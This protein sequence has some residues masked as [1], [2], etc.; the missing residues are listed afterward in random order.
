MTSARAQRDGGI[1]MTGEPETPATT[2]QTRRNKPWPKFAWLG[3]AALLVGGLVLVFNSS[4]PEA[5]VT[6]APDVPRVEG[7]RIAFSDTFA[8]RIGLETAEVRLGPL[9]PVISVVGTVALDPEHLAAVGTRLRGLVRSMHKFEGDDVKKGELLAEID[10]AELGEAQASVR[11]LGAQR[12]AAKM[13]AEREQQ[14]LERQLSTARE[15]EVAMA[16]LKKYDALQK[17][18]QQRVR[19][20]SGQS[21][22]GNPALGRYS[23]RSPIDGTIIDRG[24]STGQSVEA[25]LVAFRIA[26]LDY[27]WVELAVFERSLNGIQ[28]DDKVY[29]SPLSDP[30]LRIEGRVEHIGAQINP[31]TRS[32]DVRIE[33]D[34][35]S[36]SLRPGQAVTAEIH[37]SKAATGPVLVIPTSA[38][39]VVDGQPT[40]FVS[41]GPTTVRTVPVQLGQA[42]ENEQQVLSGLK[43]G[44]R[45]VV[46]GVFALKS[47]L[48]R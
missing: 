15:A 36:R 47:E 34:N 37:A 43:E 26:N 1:E 23:L 6:V 17:A 7:E 4:E 13:N 19:A 38:V 32:A 41:E 45:V 25:D 22:E 12:D 18:A 8:K 2:T 27:L 42:S 5:S 31:D 3:G 16:E 33:I 30:N 40:V 44:Q 24:I 14:L 20:L 35:R 39:T 29:L 11:M 28:V 10:S 21:G 48:F 9:T 46:K